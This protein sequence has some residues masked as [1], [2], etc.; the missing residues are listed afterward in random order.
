MPLF[1]WLNKNGYTN[2]P[3]GFNPIRLR[4]TDRGFVFAIAHVKI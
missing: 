1:Q 2:N 4:F 3:N